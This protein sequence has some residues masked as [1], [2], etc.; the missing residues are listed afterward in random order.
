VIARLPKEQRSLVDLAFFAGLTHSEIAAH[1]G[2]PL[3]TVKSRLR[4]AIAWLKKE[5]QPRRKC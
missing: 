3:G 5:L 2:E 1:T 4:A